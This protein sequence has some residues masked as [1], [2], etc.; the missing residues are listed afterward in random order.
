MTCSTTRCIPR[1]RARWPWPRRCWPAFGSAGVRLARLAVPAPAIELADCAS[2][3]DIT[4]ATW[5]EVC[6][7]A[8]GFYRTTLPIRFDPAER[9]AKARL[10]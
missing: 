8:A 6:R 5:K 3:F 10:P 1:S 7:F 9:E 4:T 2:H